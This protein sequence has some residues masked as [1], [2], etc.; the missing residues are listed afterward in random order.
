VKEK[1]SKKLHTYAIDLQLRLE[2]DEGPEFGVDA[3]YPLDTADVEVVRLLVRPINEAFGIPKS[4]HKNLTHN[5]SV[6]HV[7]LPNNLSTQ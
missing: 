4:I 5:F 7:P 6:S 3:G 2:A 1:G